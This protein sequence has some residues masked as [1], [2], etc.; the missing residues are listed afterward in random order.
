VLLAIGVPTRTSAQVTCV[1]GVTLGLAYGDSTAS[2]AI[3]PAVDVDVFTFEAQVGTLVRLNVRGTSNDLDPQLELFAPG[4]LSVD[5]DPFAC[6]AGFT[7]T[8]SFSTEFEPL[9]SGTYQLL[10][11]DTGTNNTGDYEISLNC[12]VGDCDSDGVPPGDPDPPLLGYDD[13]VASEIWRAW[14]RERV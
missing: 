11:E 13:P 7:A 12:L 8:C 3:S 4:G 14:G 2:C 10:V 9:V 1:E 6:S 5:L